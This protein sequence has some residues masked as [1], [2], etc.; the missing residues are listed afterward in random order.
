MGVWFQNYANKVDRLPILNVDTDMLQYGQYVAQ[1]L[2][3]ASMAIK[4]YGINKR[5]AEV[6]ADQSAAPFGGVLG[7]SANDYYASGASGGY[8]GRPLGGVP[9][10]ASR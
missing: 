9:P 6:N 5:V 2:R 1:Q 3:N 7:Q 10:L 4:G 8:Y